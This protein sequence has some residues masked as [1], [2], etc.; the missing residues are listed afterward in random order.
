MLGQ[1]VL[2]DEFNR[3]KSNPDTQRRGYLLE[4]VLVQA[5]RKAHFKVEHN[6]GMATPRQTD[7]TATYGA[8]RYLI[9]AKW[10]SEPLNN[11]HID[12]MRLARLGR[13][14]GTVVGVIF[15]VS[16]FRRS[17]IQGVSASREHSVLLFGEAELERVLADPDDLLRLLQL[18]RD[19][20][21]IRGRAH[22]ETSESPK[23]SAPRESHNL[24]VASA[25][26]LDRNKQ[27]LPFVTSGGRFGQFTFV[28][29]LADIDWGF[30]AG[31]G[32]ALDLPVHVD[33]AEDIVDLLHEMHHMGWVT[34]QPRWNIQ[35]AHVNW[36][37]VGACPEAAV[38]RVVRRPA[39]VR[40]A[41]GRVLAGRR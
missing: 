23:R 36:H 29:T 11:R 28:Q 21:V 15:S 38:G 32:V 22:L 4:Q 40:P 25:S 3:L 39:A 9:E 8:D 14:E 2:L 16:G 6:P 41:P 30:G 37:G 12:D 27:P 24:P 13:T 18:K 17:A 1:S 19:E 34:D 33:N 5:F 26:L 35:Q 7:L 10:E 31:F 20:L